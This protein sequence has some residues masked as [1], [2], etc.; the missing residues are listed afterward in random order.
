MSPQSGAQTAVELCCLTASTLRYHLLSNEQATVL[1]IDLLPEDNIRQLVQ[2]QLPA[3]RREQ[4]MRRFAYVKKDISKLT[5]LGLT[6]LTT[7]HLGVVP[8]AVN[9]FHAGWPCQSTSTA[10]QQTPAWK[11]FTPHRWPDGQARSKLAKRDDLLLS[12]IVDLFVTIKRKNHTAL[13]TIEQPENDLFLLLT[14]VKRLL[15]EGWAVLRGSHCRAASSQLDAMWQQDPVYPRKHSIYLGWGLANPPPKLLVCSNDCLMRLEQYPS[16]HRAVICRRANMR[17]GQLVLS[18]KA[19]KGRIPYYVW[20]QLWVSNCK[21]RNNIPDIRTARTELKNSE[22]PTDYLVASQVESRKDLGIKLHARLNHSQGKNLSATCKELG[23]RYQHVTHKLKESCRSCDAGKMTRTP[24][25]GHLPRGRF[26]GDVLHGDIQ[27][28]EVADING[29]RYNLMLVEDTTR[30]KWA[31]PLKLKSDAGAIF[32]QFC[33]QEFIPMIFRTDGAGEFSKVSRPRVYLFDA[34]CRVLQVCALFGIH[35]QETVADDHDQ[36]GVAEAANRR[37]AEGVRTIMYAAN[38]PKE[39]WGDVIQAWAD[40]DWFIVNRTEKFSPFFLRYGRPPV[41]EV[42]ELRT[43]GSRV[44][45]YGKR[46]DAEKL[47]M[48]GHRAIYLGRD[49]QNGGYKLLDIEAVDPVVRVVT[50][51]S[52]ASFDEMIDFEPTGMN[53]HDIRLTTDDMPLKTVWHYPPVRAVEDTI[54]LPDEQGMGSMWRLYQQY[55]ELRMLALRKSHP[56]MAP[57]DAQRQIGR[58]WREEIKHERYRDPATRLAVLAERAKEMLQA[59]NSKHPTAEKPTEG[60]KAGASAAT[61]GR[62]AGAAANTTPPSPDLRSSDHHDEACEICG[63]TDDGADMLLCDAC[64]KGYHWTCLGAPGMPSEPG[65]GKLWVCPKCRCS[66]A[67]IRI[68][69]TTART[70]SPKFREATIL[71][72]RPDGTCKI[73]WKDSSEPAEI[74]LDEH[75][76]HAVADEDTSTP[77]TTAAVFVASA[78]ELSDELLY[79]RPPKN[80]REALSEGNIL[81]EYWAGAMKVHYEKLFKKNV[82][83]V[84]NREDLPK[85]ALRLATMWVYVCKADKFSARLVVLGNRA[86]PSEIPTSSPTPRSSVWKFLFAIGV[87]LG[88]PIRHM[89]LAAGF[90]HTRPQRQVFVPMPDGLEGQGKY[91]LIRFNLFGMPEAPA[92]LFIANRNFMTTYGLVPSSFDPCV[93]LRSKEKESE[94]PLVFVVLW[95]D[96]FA[97]IAPSDWSDAFVAAYSKQFDVDDLGLISRWM[98]MEMTWVPEGLYMTHIRQCEIIVHRANLTDN[99][100]VQV[101][102]PR[103]RM[104]K[105][106]CCQSKADEEFMKDKNYRSIVGAIGYLANQGIRADLAW[107]HSELA[108]YSSCPGP[109]HWEVLVNLIHFIRKHPYT[110]VLLP[111]AGGFEI[112]ACCDSDYDGCKDER[113]SKTGVTLDIGGALFLHLSRSQKW[114]A[115]S[116]GQ[117]EYHA[118]ATCAAELLFYRQVLKIL[119][120]PV[121][122]CPVYKTEKPAADELIPTLFSDSTVA[123]GNAIKPAN[124]LSEKLKHMEIHINFFRQYVQEGFFKL[125]KIES[126]LNPSDLLTKPFATRESFNTAAAHFMKELPFRFRPSTKTSNP[127]EARPDVAQPCS[128]GVGRPKQDQNDRP[129]EARPPAAGAAKQDPTKTRGEQPGAGVSF[130]KPRQKFTDLSMPQNGFS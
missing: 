34:E 65:D 16:H 74:H 32:Q 11:G 20:H 81:R 91:L 60:G 24:S 129:V 88:Y 57:N 126:S 76:W 93:Y 64:G 51:I 48:K 1:G 21:F 47:D 116:V 75:E 124:W 128:G 72:T 19:E 111:R 97:V 114:T 120:F 69:D 68:R 29:C 62:K 39:L 123:L 40:V 107:A 50:D 27:E 12:Q 78:V 31:F 9:H 49:R 70:R 5:W 44:T 15:D 35:K 98:G 117:A 30:G 85:D 43:I 96:D 113:T 45:Y 67:I 110:G 115:K 23:G 54:R 41:K 14:P 100:N 77:T 7:A 10:S 127:V 56:D 8:S 102:M 25:R 130:K 28:Y 26:Y 33:H 90:C 53:D 118:M 58:E 66:G 86:P 104:T 2:D 37:A 61:P 46:N 84:V 13:L 17:P 108:R 59:R 82:F 3:D 101:P 80:V 92:D 103:E 89:D 73:R 63:H 99:R 18:N 36:M 109:G 122:V 38:L 121:G 94:W 55:R 87:K 125:A 4:C 52:K 79:D 71:L 119:G 112:R 105:A 42:S 106:M 22:I 95:I 6:E 83:V